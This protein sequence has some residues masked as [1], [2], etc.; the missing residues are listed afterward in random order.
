[1]CT[2]FTFRSKR[3]E[4][5]AKGFA[6][7]RIIDAH[8]HLYPPEVN[9]SPVVWAKAQGELHW[10]TLCTR[11]RKNGRAVQGFPSVD[12]LL[13]DLDAAGIEHAVLQGW[14]WEKH[15]TCVL[16]NRF[17]EACIKAHPD[18]LTAFAAFH[19]AAGSVVV[20]QE[21]RRAANEGFR[22]LGELSPH[23]QKVPIDDLVWCQVMGLAG[24]FHLPVNLHVTEPHSKNYPGKVETPLGDFV[25]LAKKFPGTNFVLAHWGAQLPLDPVLGAA[26]KACANLYYDCAASPVLYDRKIYREMINAVGVDRVLYGSDHPLDL[27][28][29]SGLGPQLGALLDDVRAAGLSDAELRLVLRQNV[30]NLLRF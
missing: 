12:E 27:Y 16:Q 29:M 30:A 10:S 23:S 24:K 7:M 9:Q 17:Y 3:E 5:S 21:I 26:A 4:S 14:Y 18:R 2:R 6:V 19:P 1:L 15:D 28:P 20:A 13:R 25:V 11:V 22:G 8:V